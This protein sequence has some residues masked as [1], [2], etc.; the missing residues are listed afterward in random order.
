[1]SGLT[2]WT[3]RNEHDVDDTVTVY[4]APMA[5]QMLP[6]EGEETEWSDWQRWAY[7]V[8]SWFDPYP[9]AHNFKHCTNEANF[10][11]C[12]AY[13]DSV[14][15][16]YALKFPFDYDLNFDWQGEYVN[17]SCFDQ[18]TFNDHV[19]IRDLNNKLV[20]LH[21]N[22]IFFTEEKSLNLESL[23]AYTSDNNFI[24][25]TVII[26]GVFDIGKW[27]RPIDCTFMVK[28]N[29]D[30]IKMKE[31]DQWNHTRFHTNK[32]VKLQKFYYN[33]KLDFL[34]TN[35]VNVRNYKTPKA[36]SWDYYYDTFDRSKYKDYILDEIKQNLL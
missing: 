21:F 22:Y 30:T 25:S 18:K 3:K 26:P 32:K 4:W 9:I 23:T 6:K 19:Y 10:K 34:S 36:N 27:F 12:P 11:V 1:M 35:L 13:V 28:Q 31:G 20:T 5:P 16:T 15:N 33:K 17:S 8:S 24:N 14:K 7:P 29:V 2:R